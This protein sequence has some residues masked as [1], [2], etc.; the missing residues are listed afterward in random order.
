[1]VGQV[2]ATGLDATGITPI[3]KYAPIDPVTGRYSIHVPAGNWLVSYQIFTDTYQADLSTPLIVTAAANQTAPLDL[4]LIGMD[5]FVTAEVRDQAGVLQP[6]VTVWV[7]YGSQEVYAETDSEGR[8]TVYVPY[9]NIDLGTSAIR[10]QG[11]QQ[12]PIKIGTSYSNCNKSSK[13]DKSQP[14]GGSK[15]CRNSS[16]ALAKAPQPK[17]KPGGL[18]A[19]AADAP[20]ELSLRDTND[21]LTG[22]VLNPGGQTTRAG[23][24]VS[25]WSSDGQWIS[26]ATDASGAFS[27]PIVQ[28]STIST[29]WQVTASYWDSETKKLLSKGIPVNVALGHAPDTPIA[30]GDL[31]LGEIT[32]VLPPSESQQFSNSAGLTLPLSDGTLIQIPKSAMPDGFGDRVR[33]TVAPQ[34]ELPSTDLNRT[35]RYYGYAINLYDAQTGRPIEQPL[36]Q[37]AT[38]TFKYTPAQLQQLGINEDDLQPAQFADDTWHVADGFLQDKKGDERAISVATTALD[39]WALV[40]EQPVKAQGGGARVY[41][42]MIARR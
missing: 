8:V 11:Q 9:S 5:G 24:F 40:V 13:P 36:K 34:I 20:V 15:K 38:I 18:L 41:V 32:S 7:R 35:A 19:A 29:T 21:T 12:P 2:V 33:I 23:A 14:S 37:A 42:P 6:N 4:P 17:P 27:L 3:T 39:N 25:A 26:G 16:V 10:P 30:A 31:T 28:N 1:V 22:R